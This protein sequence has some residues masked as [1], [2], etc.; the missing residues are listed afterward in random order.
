M[1]LNLHVLANKALKP[2]N[3]K[4][5]CVFIRT[6]VS[7]SPD[8]LEGV[9]ETEEFKLTGFIQ[10]FNAKKHTSFNKIIEL[11]DNTT[12][13]E[14]MWVVYLRGFAT[15]RDQY[16]GVND[17]VFYARNKKYTV[18]ENI[19]WRKANWVEILCR[20]TNDDRANVNE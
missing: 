11:G 7:F 12:T 3:E 19:P 9:K 6:K 18:I 15:M 8:S 20:E 14:N 4:I 17:D 2:V 5:E 16:R 13:T 10:P 1:V